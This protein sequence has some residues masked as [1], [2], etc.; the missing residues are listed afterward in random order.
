MKIKK[1]SIHGFKSFV[2]KVTLHFPAGTSGIIGPNGCG[3]SNIVD[4]I[5]WVLGEQNARHLR[6]KHMED[7]IFNGSEN[8]KPLGMAEVVLTF[9]NEGGLASS[10][11]ANFTEIEISRRLYR[12]GESEYYINKVQSRLKD[13]VDLF[14]D[15]GIGTRAYSIIEQGQVG[16][17]ITAKAEERR[18]IFEEAAGI[19][20]FKHKKDAALRRLES[21]RENLTRVNDIISEVKRQLN[22]LNRQAKKAERYKALKE[23][24]KTLELTLSS[25]E[26]TKM[27]E[28]LSSVS[29][30]LEAV[31]DEEVAA[32]TLIAA[33]EEQ[34]EEL[35]VE[36]LGVEG[37]YKG[38]R[39]RVFEAERAIQNEEQGRA[40]AQM[41]I[42]ELGRSQERLRVEIEEIASSREGAS[43]EIEALRQSLSELASLIDADSAKL[44]E[45]SK[46]LE[47]VSSELRAREEAQR[48]LKAESFK[49]SSRFSDI[50]NA[51]GNCLRD[52]EHL[53][54]RE[55]KARTEIEAAAGALASKEEPIKAL[56]ENI[57]AASSRKESLQAELTGVRQS[58]EVFEKDRSE[59]AREIS[60]TKDEY[61]KA[62]AMLATLESMDRNLESVKGGAKAIMQRQDK[63]GVYGLIADCIET[64]PGYERA[65]EAVLAD[66][67]QYVL[68]E[69]HREGVDAIEYLKSK[70]GGRASFVPVSE[71]RPAATPV[72]AQ[73][74][75]LSG[76]RELVKELRIKEGFDAIVTCLLGDVFVADNLETA[77]SAWKE[78]GGYRTFVTAEGE[79]I[80]GQG[81]MTGGS[82]LSGSGILQRRGEIKKIKA[83]AE[84]LG[85]QISVLEQELKSL[86]EKILSEKGN[87]DA[88]R[89][90]LHKSE[91]E[92]VNLG[93]EL[94][95]QEDDAERLRRT[96][97]SLTAEVADAERKL[98][99]TG[100]KK[101]ALSRE[102]EGLE[103]NIAGID[104]KI[105]AIGEEASGLMRKKEEISA[106]V[107]E[108]RVKLASSRER[109]ESGKREVSTKER[110]IEESGRRIEA[111]K[112]EI[113][114]GRQEI[115]T[116]ENE[117]EAIKERLE[118]LLSTIDG[119][120]KEEVAKAETLDAL[121]TQI[122]TIEHE[123]K[124]VKGKYTE[125][126][127]LKGELTIEVR[128]MELA[129]KGLNERMQEKYGTFLQE[130][131]PAEGEAV[132][133]MESLEENREGLREKI[134]SIGEVSLSA[135]EEFNDL[136]RRH[137]FLL[138]QQADLT[139]SVDALHTAIQRINRTTREKFRTTFDEINAKF[140]ETFPR[141]FN[142]GRAELRLT[143]ESNDILEA[144]V[145]IAAQPPGKRLQ[146]I[147]LLSGGE[148]ALTATAL[149]FAIF[150]I[151]PS[152][153]C[154]LDE[155][156]APLDDANIDRF[157]MFVRDMSKISQFLL[158]THNKKTMEMADALYGITMQEPGVSKMI[159]L[160]F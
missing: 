38:I 62:S 15:T 74:G 57:A 20:K 105:A 136:E 122:K 42:E 29:K 77:I 155:V 139:K 76:V 52:E 68:V 2:D 153:F 46:S 112:A 53:R 50:R 48:A 110:S 115:A 70:N 8:R 148:K 100:T 108:A 31:K 142:G 98:A 71:A 114:R 111:K 95:R 11:F 151:K 126:Q 80:D 90:R 87:I 140:Q 23:E 137:Q 10:R 83:S 118:A 113:E 16:W 59:K 119:I 103:G 67:L 149:I 9:S 101:A 116:K 152:P 78:S 44:N 19:N 104:S 82:A 18:S 17:L 145:E 159:T 150:L 55:A 13:I 130:Y 84:V 41:R 143:E 102:R 147:T 21:T 86:D 54:A 28:A 26:F 156:D 144:G 93:S 25:L 107:T 45:N 109:L 157:N 6:G 121:S 128:E 133:D 47:T 138:D 43:K 146:N 134:A 1:I 160:K 72:P 92:K 120:K 4:A 97:D 64:N 22:S 79:I 65:V 33:K 88:L 66:K 34:A 39:E 69:S 12:S 135:L 37:E 61:S 125:A 89:E 96:R 60:R 24:L 14:T 32:G 73:A 56:R 117:A 85:Q 123:L 7:I 40:L 131:R 51:I 158:I 81:V 91:I 27:R 141:F 106:I 3:K 49:I 58:L 124:E 99:E 154:L 35:K 132:P 63:T 127:E 30:R 75:Q 129:I 36:H 94:K 5:R